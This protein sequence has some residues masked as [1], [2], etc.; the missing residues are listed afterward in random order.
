MK[1]NRHLGTIDLLPDAAIPA[2]QIAFDQLRARRM[3]Q[4][5]VR[6]ALNRALAG[7]GIDPV[8]KSAFYRWAAKVFDGKRSRP[9]SAD[10]PTPAGNDAGAGR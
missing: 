7:L 1:P 5:G 3:Q 4:K 2:L 10:V 9:A 6:D 8:S